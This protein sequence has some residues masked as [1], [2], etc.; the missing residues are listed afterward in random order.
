MMIFTVLTYI[1]ITNEEEVM[2]LTWRHQASQPARCEGTVRDVTSM[3]NHL[4]LIIT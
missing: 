3:I 1:Y 2:T 4:I